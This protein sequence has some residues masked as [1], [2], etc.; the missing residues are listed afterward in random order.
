M[1]L[2]HSSTRRSPSIL[3]RCCGISCKPIFGLA[4]QWDAGDGTLSLL[5]SLPLITSFSPNNS[6]SLFLSTPLS[7]SRSHL[8]SL[9]L[10]L[11][12]LPF[13]LSLPRSLALP[14]SL[15]PCRSFPL[16]MSNALFLSLPLSHSLSLWLFLSLFYTLARLISIARSA[17]GSNL[18]EPPLSRAAP[19]RCRRTDGQGEK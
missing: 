10:S 11:N 18:H 16:S 15:T 12:S 6:L 2:I 7:L 9:P 17:F 1:F 14:L 19:H 8:P 5:P 4:S 13:F 3:R